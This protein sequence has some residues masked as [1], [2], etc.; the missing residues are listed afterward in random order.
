MPA[1]AIVPPCEHQLDAGD[2]I[3]V[4]FLFFRTITPSRI[5][6]LIQEILN[7]FEVDRATHTSYGAFLE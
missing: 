2:R 1:S 7:A 3:S 4:V 6:L 5:K